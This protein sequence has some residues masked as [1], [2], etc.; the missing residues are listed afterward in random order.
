MFPSIFPMCSFL[1]GTRFI[2]WTHKKTHE[3]PQPKKQREIGCFLWLPDPS[4]ARIPARPRG[5]QLAM[6]QSMVA[7][8]PLNWGGGE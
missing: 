5:L 2:F 6:L 8:Y 7:N 1:G 4:G 3:K